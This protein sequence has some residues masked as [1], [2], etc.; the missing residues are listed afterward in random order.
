MFKG[1]NFFS[2][3]ILKTGV[4]VKAS[5]YRPGQAHRVPGG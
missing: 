1:R 2:D 3:M 5:L 4:K